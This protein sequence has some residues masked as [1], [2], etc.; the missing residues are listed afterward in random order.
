M[1]TIPVDLGLQSSVRDA[2]RAISSLTSTLDLLINN[3]GVVVTTRQTT[4]DGIE[5]QFATNHLGPFLLTNL[6]LPLLLKAAETKP[7]GATRVVSLSSAGHRL[8]PIRFS[9]VNFT[10]KT[11]VPPEEDHVK[12]LAGAFAKTTEDGY[13]GIVTYAQSKTAN[14]LFTKALRERVGGRGVGVYSLHPGCKFFFLS[15]F[16]VPFVCYYVAL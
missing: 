9:D 4:P 15:L 14:I 16:F 6:L 8:S 7:A 12:P 5:R 13:N 2:A 10:G 1:E 3:A 11:Q